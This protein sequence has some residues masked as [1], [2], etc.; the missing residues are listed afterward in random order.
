[1]VPQ[2]RHAAPLFYRLIHHVLEGQCRRDTQ[3]GYGA[4]IE[5]DALEIGDRVVLACDRQARPKTM[6]PL[7]WKSSTLLSP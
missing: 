1:M 4:Q 3:A 5:H 6:A 2:H 7:S